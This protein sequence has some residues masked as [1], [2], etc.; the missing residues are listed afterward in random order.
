MTKTITIRF[1][2]YD[3]D[4]THWLDMMPESVD[5]VEEDESFIIDY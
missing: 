1:E 3:D 2:D 5:I 4:A